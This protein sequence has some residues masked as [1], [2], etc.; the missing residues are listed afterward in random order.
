[1]IRDDDVDPERRCVPH[2][3]GRRNAVVHREDDLR[4]IRT[5]DQEIDD[6]GREAVTVAN[7]VGYEVVDGEA[8]RAKAS[9]S[10]CAGRG[11]VAVVVGDDRDAFPAGTSG[12]KP[13]GGAVDSREKVRSEHA[14]PGFVEVFGRADAA[15]REGPRHGRE[16]PRRRENVRGVRIVGTGDEGRHAASEPSTHQASG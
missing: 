2:G 7:T 14:A 6:R 12:K 9:D 11:A 8:E 1:M 16:I 4:R 13:F 15:R 3:L 5:G 10:D